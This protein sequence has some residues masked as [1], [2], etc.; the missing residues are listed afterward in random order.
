M[1]PLKS[2]EQEYP[3]IDYNFHNFCASH[4]I[5]SGPFSPPTFQAP[6]LR[7]FSSETISLLTLVFRSNVMFDSLL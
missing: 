4:G 5:F 2:L 1:A 6:F 3:I 7:L